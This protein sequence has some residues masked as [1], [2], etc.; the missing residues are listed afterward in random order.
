MI[1]EL[2]MVQFYFNTWVIFQEKKS[3]EILFYKED[4]IVV[5]KDK[6]SSFA[7]RDF[8]K[9]IYIMYTYQWQYR[10]LS[11]LAIMVIKATG[12]YLALLIIC[13]KL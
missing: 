7:A 10:A 6:D 8:N 2:R 1:Y 13:I 11:I 9:V 12:K 5:Y 4:N 3:E